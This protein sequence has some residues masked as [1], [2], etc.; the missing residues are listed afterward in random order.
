MAN[1]VLGS[2]HPIVLIVTSDGV[3]AS[4]TDIV[5]RILGPEVCVCDDLDLKEGFRTAL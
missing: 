2:R 1:F 4:P 3:A 5:K